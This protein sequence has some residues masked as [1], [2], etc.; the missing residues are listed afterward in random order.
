MGSRDHT[1][2]NQFHGAA[3]GRDMQIWGAELSYSY[4]YVTSSGVFPNWGARIK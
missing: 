1:T 2:R 4:L 3:L